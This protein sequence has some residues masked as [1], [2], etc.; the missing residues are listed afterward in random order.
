MA[1][2]VATILL[3]C[4]PIRGLPGCPAGVTIQGTGWSE[5]TYN[6]TANTWSWATGGTGPSVREF[7][8]GASSATGMTIFGGLNGTGAG[9]AVNDEGLL[10]DTWTWTPGSFWSAAACTPCNPSPPASAGAAM[11]YQ[12][13]TSQGY[14]Y[15]GYTDTAPPAAPTATWIWTGTGWQG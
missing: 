14:F 5:L 1:E 13:A 10:A 3:F 6:T 4:Y 12:R 2:T 7:T 9:T 11:A 15:G 8:A